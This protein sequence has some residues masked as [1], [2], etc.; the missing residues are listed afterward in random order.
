[1]PGPEYRKEILR[2][3]AQKLGF[4]L[5]G[6]LRVTPSQT[7]AI[8]V[9]WLQ[10][11]YAG[12]MGYLERHTELKRDVRT[13]L[14]EAQTLVALGIRYAPPE[15]PPPQPGV[16]RISRYALGVDYHDVV[17]EKLNA[18]AAFAHTELGLAAPSRSFVDSG[19][20]LEREYAQRAGLGWFGKHSCIIHPEQGSY[21]F[22]AELLL[23]ADLPEDSPFTRINC[24]SCTRCIDVCPTDAIVADRTVDARR[25]ISYLTIEL[26]GEIPEDLRPGMGT[27]LFGCDL[28][29]EVCPWNRR[30][31][32][33]DAPEFEPDPER[34]QPHL[35]EWMTWDEEAFRKRFRKTPLWRTKRRGL[36]RNVAVA[37]GNW[38]SP[39]AVPVLVQALDDPEPLIRQHAAWALRTIG[40]PAAEQALERLRKQETDPSVLKELPA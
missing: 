10:Q 38:G 18:L 3:H 13:L 27:H 15:V 21:F 32:A 11:G 16:G 22:L 39:E 28:C 12:A 34:L 33:A 8:Y 4:S 9:N 29:Q 6:T 23:A 37:L 40:G 24:G 35:L 17:R 2:R 31:P 36:L 7:H 25:C 14:P 20:V 19:P 26:K 5:F 1:M 30:A